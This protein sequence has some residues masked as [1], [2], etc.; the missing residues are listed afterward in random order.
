MY[1][2]SSTYQSKVKATLEYLQNC[3]I[4][5]LKLRETNIFNFGYKNTFL[6]HICVKFWILLN[7]N[8]KSK[9]QKYV[10]KRSM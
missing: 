7:L 2:L 9:P 6:W 8:V 10:H 1:I 5:R 4:Y 3:I